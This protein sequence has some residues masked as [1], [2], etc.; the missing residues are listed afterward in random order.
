VGDH[1]EHLRTRAILAGKRDER[2][3]QVVASAVSNAERI[4]IAVEQLVHLVGRPQ[5][6]MLDSLVDIIVGIATPA[7][8]V[9]RAWNDVVVEPR[10]AA[11]ARRPELLR[12]GL[13]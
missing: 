8:A 7:I 6:V 11:V 12:R 9:D 3:A 13:E 10:C 2:A 4:E 1:L 5:I